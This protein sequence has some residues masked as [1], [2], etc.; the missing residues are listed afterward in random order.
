[1]EIEFVS[2]GVVR[3]ALVL[4]GLV[5]LAPAIG[6]LGGP[7]LQRLYG[8]EP[9]TPMETLLLRHRA[10]LFGIVGGGLVASAASPALHGVALVV[11]SLAAGSF[12]L[13]ARG[14]PGL[15]PPLRRVIWADR[16]CMVLLGVAA[17]AHG[18]A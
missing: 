9:S 15:T 12:L 2:F 6:V 11:G 18:L 4:V 13:L 16:F 17:A 1:M 8:F 10:V 5:H 14:V 7:R 3:T